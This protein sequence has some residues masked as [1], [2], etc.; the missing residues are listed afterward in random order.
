MISKVLIVVP[1]LVNKDDEGD[2]NPDRPDFEAYRLVSPVEPTVVGADLL[3]RGFDVKMFDIGTY[4]TGSFEKLSEF[5][6]VFKPDGVVM[7]QSILTFAT[8]QDWNG[9][10]VFDLAR[11]KSPNVVTVLTGTNVSSSIAVQKGPGTHSPGKR[12]AAD[13][14]KTF[15]CTRRVRALH[16]RG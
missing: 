13:C 15:R 12:A 10:R 2:F 11:S 6:D 4:I 14:C 7:V 1:P 5:M 16:D 9:K 3:E 8:A